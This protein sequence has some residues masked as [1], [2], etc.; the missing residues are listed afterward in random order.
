LGQYRRGWGA[1]T[2]PTFT[3]DIYGRL[4]TVGTAA[5]AG[6]L[7][8]GLS[9][10]TLYNSAG[11]W[12]ATSNLFNNGTNVGIG[13]TSPTQML[14]I[15]NGAVP[16]ALALTTSAALSS[17]V[18]FGTTAV[19]N[20]GVIRYNNSTN[21]MDFLTNN[22]VT[23]RISINSVGHT[24]VFTPPD[25]L[26]TFLVGDMGG[27]LA[28]GV[29]NLGVKIGDVI[30][31][32]MNNYFY[33]DF[34]G[35]G[36]FQ[37]I[38]GN[39]G[40]GTA[41]PVNKLDV[42]GGLSVGAGYA[43]TIGAPSNGA[44]IQGNVGIGTNGPSDNLHVFGNVNS[45]VGITI[46]NMNSGASSG[47][48]I[49]FNNEDG[50]VAGIAMSDIASITP[51]S[52]SIFNNRPSGNIRLNTGG[53]TKVYISNN[54]FVGIGLN[55]S[56]PAGLLHLKG[57]EWDAAPLI[58]ESNGAIGPS[59]RFVANTRT[60]DIIATNGGTL[61]SDHFGIWDN[62]GG[63]YRFVLTP[64]GNIGI[65]TNVPTALLSVNGSANK[66]G[67]GTWAV[68]SDR[69][70]KENISD[71]TESSEILDKIHLVNYQYNSNYFELFG[72]NDE[73]EQAVYTGVIAQELQQIAPNMVKTRTVEKR[74]SKGNSIGTQEVLEVDPSNFTYL[75]I[76]GYKK[77]QAE[78]EELKIQI[79]AQ[80]K[81]IQLL[82]DKSKVI[83]QK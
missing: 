31:G 27:N 62:T 45:N 24:G 56:A 74:D 70:L 76:N 60:Y 39:V 15:N 17:Q 32:S 79:E 54:G 42:S 3:V 73:V 52:M 8:V 18:M 10:Q 9:G 25:P 14:E 57:A 83:E 81:Q 47:E 53:N 4:T 65:G 1:S 35:A 48:R 59:L 36:N 20:R 55:F 2:I 28:L 23:P 63:A 71:F 77:Q 68:F 7:P 61:P 13:T 46:Q 69:R 12:T 34:E 51:G 67:G 19:P 75:L 33:T 80:Q 41:T 11:T 37:F 58:L 26:F 38:G 6:L 21:T 16:P 72:K 82:L 44:I 5:I 49:S 64:T 66:P 43:G 40:I 29:D 50:G 22:T 30:G 78:I